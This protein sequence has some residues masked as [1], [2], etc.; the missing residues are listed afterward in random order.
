MRGIENIKRSW[1]DRIRYMNGCGQEKE[2]GKRKD[3]AVA[4]MGHTRWDTVVCPLSTRMDR[5]ITIQSNKE[6]VFLCVSSKMTLL[7]SDFCT[8]WSLSQK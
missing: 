1:R 3:S 7:K 5:L 4:K 2:E 6:S 8:L